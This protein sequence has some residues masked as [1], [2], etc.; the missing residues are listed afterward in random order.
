MEKRETDKDSRIYIPKEH[1]SN[2]VFESPI[3]VSMKMPITKQVNSAYQCTS[4]FECLMFKLR[5]QART[6]CAGSFAFLIQD[7]SPSG[8]MLLNL[9]SF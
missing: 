9:C 7:S 6:P 8:N 2:P 3:S 1:N 4:N 5:K